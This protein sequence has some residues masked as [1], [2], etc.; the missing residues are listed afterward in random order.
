MV[1]TAV[2]VSLAATLLCSGCAEPAA[3]PRTEPPLVAVVRT[4]AARDGEQRFT[5]IVR[6]RVESELGFRIGGKVLARLVD[7]GEAVRRGQPLMRLDPTDLALDATA[8]RSNVAAARARSIEAA[9]NFARLNGLV[10]QGAISAQSYDQAKAAADSAAAQLGAA[11]AQARVA[12]NARAYAVLTADADGI[13]QET[14]AEPGQVVAAGQAVIRLAHAGPREAEVS[15][16][17]TLRPPLGARATATLYGSDGAAFPAIL[18]LLSQTADAATR[19]YPARFVLQG[20]GSAAPLGSTVTVALA[21]PDAAGA[22]EVPLG[23]VHDAG[24]GPGVWIVQNGR[25][26]FAP[27]RLLALRQETALVAG[28]APD[29]PIVA[30]GAN[31]L[32]A[33]QRVRTTPRIAAERAR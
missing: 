32:R 20:R 26:R 13:V 27:V 6:A 11:Q 1:R 15:L 23:A 28:L 14:N 17:E 24:R 19:T 10:E 22:L 30:M 4:A 12:G 2:I 16:P 8:Q 21:R 9:A 33:G 3:D 5:G 7:P 25:L 29:Q 18:R 31:R